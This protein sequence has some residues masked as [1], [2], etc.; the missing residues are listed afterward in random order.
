M[1]YIQH[2]T[3]THHDVDTPH[4]NTH[5]FPSSHA[6]TNEA[7]DAFAK[8][9]GGA[10]AQALRTLAAA[11]AAPRGGPAKTPAA[12]AGQP[13]PRLRGPARDPYAAVFKPGT[14]TWDTSGP[15]NGGGAG[16]G[17]Q[18][19]KKQGSKHSPYFGM[20]FTT[21]LVLGVCVR[22]KEWALLTYGHTCSPL[23]SHKPL[24]MH[25]ISHTPLISHPQRCP[26]RR[27]R[28]QCWEAPAGPLCP[29]VCG[30]QHICGCCEQGIYIHS[31]GTNSK[32]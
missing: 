13:D 11:K 29:Q 9:G 1:V 21:V 22:G 8:G 10:R 19:K 24:S 20:L 15:E 27:I 28:S 17:A 16:A 6:G 4:S 2:Y 25:L 12:A 3:T 7:A 5:H 30:E 14:S 31:D 23:I 18:Q 32:K 26:T